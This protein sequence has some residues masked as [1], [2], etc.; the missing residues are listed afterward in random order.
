M[1]WGLAA[2]KKDPVPAEYCPE[3]GSSFPL[4]F[5][6]PGAEELDFGVLGTAAEKEGT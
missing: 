4:T 6:S 5:V 1:Q 2:G 3:L